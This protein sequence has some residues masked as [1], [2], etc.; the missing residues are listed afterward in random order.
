MVHIRK[1]QIKIIHTEGKLENLLRRKCMRNEAGAFVG[2]AVN[3]NRLYCNRSQWRRAT[4]IITTSFTLAAIARS[5]VA[6]P[7]FFSPN[8]SSE[9]FARERSSL[10]RF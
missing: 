2:G 7:Y 10:I 1:L 5:L 9:C 8:A 3:T 4:I 6:R